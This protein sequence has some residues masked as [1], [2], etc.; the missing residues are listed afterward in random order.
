ME[1]NK[2]SWLGWLLLVLSLVGLLIA[3]VLFLRSRRKE[4]QADQIQ[5]NPE[6]GT[7]GADT[8][9]AVRFYNV[10]LDTIGDRASEPIVRIITAQAMHE[11]GVFTSPVFMENNNA[12]G[13]RQPEKRPT[14]SIGEN[15]GYA[16]YESVED[17]IRDLILWF[18]YNKIPVEFNSV[19]AYTAKIRE[20]SY[21]EAGYADY[22]ASVKMHLMK[23][24]SMV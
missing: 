20:Y 15:R 3:L 21:Y 6:Q 14:V 16:V 17:S 1:Q 11:T 9:D 23:L 24:N 5:D 22:T 8:M 10:A 12:F 7:S 19:G 2:K 18:D 13:M 4:T